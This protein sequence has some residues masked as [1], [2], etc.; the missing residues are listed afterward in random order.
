MDYTGTTQALHLYSESAFTASNGDV[1]VYSFLEWPNRL[2]NTHRDV[3]E[4]EVNG[5]W[6]QIYARWV[7]MSSKEQEQSCGSHSWSVEQ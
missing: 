1:V 5:N 4:L 7:P 3:V 6:E 2:S